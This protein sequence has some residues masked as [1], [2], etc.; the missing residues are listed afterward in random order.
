MKVL[1]LGFSVL[2]GLVDRFIGTEGSNDYAIR[3]LGGNH[4]EIYPFLIKTL[5]KN[6]KPD[7]VLL[8]LV[9]TPRVAR[10]TPA[11]FSSVLRYIV[12]ECH[13]SG[14]EVAFL[15]L[16]RRDVDQEADF[17]HI[18]VLELSA[19]IG[20]PVLDVLK[21]HRQEGVELSNYY[22]DGNH[23]SPVGRAVLGDLIARFAE[24]TFADQDRC[25]RPLEYRDIDP[26][27]VKFDSETSYFRR[28][29][30]N[31]SIKTVPAGATEILNLD[32]GFQVHG[33]L[34]LMGPT[35]G[36]VSFGYANSKRSQL[37]SDQHCYYERLKHVHLPVAQSDSISIFQSPELPDIPLLKGERNLSERKGGVVACLGTVPRRSAPTSTAQPA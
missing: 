12:H 8:D 37:L 28:F 32:A 4:F 10:W 24:G 26:V 18:T 21:E 33:A 5:L 7:R 30:F 27:A 16:Y 23:P 31:E 22:P 20:A 19:Q 14:A 3:V 11:L 17:L 2:N 9:S 1:I 13:E 36:L 29:G 25:P 15:N 35:T 34:M 6:E